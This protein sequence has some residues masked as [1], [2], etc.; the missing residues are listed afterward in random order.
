MCW[1]MGAKGLRTVNVCDVHHQFR[2]L[3]EQK[4]LVYLALDMSEVH[5][6]LF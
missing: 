5:P 1:E 2:A 4:G 3:G 6:Q